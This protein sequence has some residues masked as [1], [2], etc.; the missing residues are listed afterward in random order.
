MNKNIT[1]S[2]RIFL[3]STAID[4]EEHRKK[5][6]DAIMRMGDLP[7]QMETFGALPS[8]PVEVCQNKVRE[9]DA[10]VVMSAHRYGWAPGTSE[11]GDG[12]KSITWIEVETALEAGK[13][14]FAFLV[15]MNYGWTQH[16]EQDL[17][18]QA[19][20]EEEAAKVFK[21]VQ[22]LKDFH[23]FLE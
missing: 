5:V 13:P 21:T 8:E 1:P 6:S 16:K 11:G 9:C 14:V 23:A 7:V 3:S 4:M 15:D 12:C 10:L 17:L 2:Y 22:A 18:V 19:K 20:D